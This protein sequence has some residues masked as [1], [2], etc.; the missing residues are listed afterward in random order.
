VS[1]E[2]NRVDWDACGEFDQCAA[3]CTLD[4]GCDLLT[5]DWNTEIACDAA[6]WWECVH[7]RCLLPPG[8]SCE[9]EADCVA[10]DSCCGNW[11]CSSADLVE[12]NP[13][14]CEDPG[15]HPGCRCLDGDCTVLADPETICREALNHFEHTCGY[16]VED[17]ENRRPS[18]HARLVG[19][20]VDECTP[21]LACYAAC[22]RY[23]DEDS[24]SRCHFSDDI[25]CFRDPF[26]EC[27]SL[28]D[29]APGRGLCEGT[30]GRWGDGDCE[31]CCGPPSCG[32]DAEQ[33]TRCNLLCCGPPQCYC[34]ER[35]PFW[36]ADRGC[37]S[38][39]SCSP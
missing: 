5:C 31:N 15:R 4:L 17:Q 36:E 30:H 22:L 28:C 2:Q 8:E 39:A 9:E 29:D 1:E 6:P 3:E 11:Q 25:D 20:R 16:S 35:A 12:P 27:V 10:W 32:G 13:C 37:V 33:Q 18:D 38:E 19:L 26:Q 14:D 23:D 21:G 24:C 7:E 34:P